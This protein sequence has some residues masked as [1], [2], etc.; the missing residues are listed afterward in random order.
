MASISLGLSCFVQY[1]I[2]QD[3]YVTANGRTLL[4]LRWGNF[5]LCDLK[6]EPQW[7]H[8]H[9]GTHSNCLGGAAV[10]PAQRLQ[11]L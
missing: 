2:L 3:H 9:S 1:N 7:N 11:F 10:S 4:F 8:E 5:A 6:L